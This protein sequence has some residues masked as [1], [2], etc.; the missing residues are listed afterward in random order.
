MAAN[1]VLEESLFMS[2]S[3]LC[4]AAATL[5]RTRHRTSGFNPI[6][7]DE[8]FMDLSRKIAINNDIGRGFFLFGFPSSGAGND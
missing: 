4:A 1:V 8:T 2:T 3:R 5:V 6:H 7:L